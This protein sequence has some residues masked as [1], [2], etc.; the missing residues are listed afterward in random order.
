MIKYL[1]SNIDKNKG[2]TKTQSDYLKENIT[3]NMSITF[4]ASRP[5][6]YDKNDMYKDKL[7][8]FFENNIDIK[9]KMSNLIDERVDNQKSK[10]LI[11]RH[12]FLNGW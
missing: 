12:C 10:E 8:K 3:S 1:F 5:P 4:I 6:E 11:I 2:F 7:I 9:F